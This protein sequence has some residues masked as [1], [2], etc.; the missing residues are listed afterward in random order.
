MESCM[1]VCG[2]FTPGTVGDASGAT[3]GC[4]LYHGGDPSKSAPATHCAHAGPLGDGVCGDDCD[5]F[6]ATALAVCSSQATPP[7]TDLADCKTKCAAYADT[8]K[9]PF[10]ASVTSGDSLACRMYHLSVASSSADLAQTHCSHVG[11][12]SAPCK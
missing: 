3:L 6:C 7:Y 8:T 2:T 12:D 11:Q 1:G 4:H 10:N 9:V 5:N